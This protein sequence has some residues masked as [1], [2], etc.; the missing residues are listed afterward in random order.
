[1]RYLVSI[2]SVFF[3]L[4]AGSLL[5]LAGCDS[6]GSNGNNGSQNQAPTA[7]V[8]V[9]SSM[10]DVDT[11]VTL[12]GSGSSDP[13]GDDITYSWTLDTPSG[14][15]ASL[16][17]PGAVQPTFTPD[18]Q[19]DYTA[20]LEV[21]DGD[22]SD[23]DDG[24]VTAES[25]VVE[26]DSDV[27]SDRTLTADEKYLV[28]TTVAVEDGVTLT[29]EAGTEIV[30]ENDVALRVAR[31]GAI[32]A[33]GT[34]DAPITMTATSGNEQP[35][36]WRGVAI[37]STST[38]NSLDYVE[39]R[40][41][42]SSSMNDIGRAANVAIADNQAL[43][44]TNSTIADGD[45]YGFYIAGGGSKAKADLTFSGNTFS[46][47]ADGP[48][49]IPFSNI[50]AIDS[51][52]SFPDGSS[53][54]LYGEVVEQGD[55]TVDA[56]SGDTPYRISGTAGVDG[57]STLTIEPGVN[58][59]FENDVAL[60]VNTGAALVADGTASDPITMTA[61]DGN[62][63]QGWWRGI[64]FSSSKTSN[65]LNHVTVR[66]AGSNS[67][68]G[69]GQ[70]A[71]VA[72]ADNQALTLTNST[73]ADGGGYGFYID[74]AGSI[75][76]ANLE[77]SANTFSGNADG[78]MWIP[79]SDAV[80]I[81]D[82]SSFPSG[83]TVRVYGATVSGDATLNAL[84]GD[85]PYRVSST[86][87]I[88]ATLT[89]E[90]GVEMTF[91]SDVAFWVLTGA[92]LVADGTS[93]DPITMTATTGNEQKGWWRGVAIYSSSPNNTLDHVEVRYAGSTSMSGISQA[94]NIG[95]DDGTQ[96]T[97]TNSTIADGDGWGLYCDAS[98]VSVT[99]SGNSYEFNNSGGIS[100]DCQ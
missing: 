73:I 30:F 85:T 55:V 94:A 15:N 53:V 54:R 5:V 47:N 44:L 16:S 18:V 75:S 79:F 39:V 40:Y 48:M 78:P 13:D 45:G 97:L 27:T 3:G 61:T 83:A 35:G 49:W 62:E 72:V 42:G 60:Q 65:R 80:E 84:S 21:S 70:A 87:E 57:T 96:L 10:V 9:G 77:F 4:L 56:L 31:G 91:E 66:H 2:R 37:N 26:I 88:D 25:V 51:G 58:M 1:M 19:G 71:N 93:S 28:T 89:V 32:D 14:S 98:D 8:A 69:I 59:T 67:I 36:W 20:T 23:T 76:N 50:G 74:G 41:A 6:T 81:D 95:I 29:I 100:S 43:S 12:D 52:S 33:N 82:G 63:Q 92:S 22:A 46:G 7:E 17:D 86:P 34:S 90:P 99:S 24:V 64:A 11:E 38:N 68:S